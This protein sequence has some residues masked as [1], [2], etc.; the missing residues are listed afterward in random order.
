MP[1]TSYRLVY[2]LP[3]MYH[4]WLMLA[5]I[6][7][8]I[9]SMAVSD[10]LSSTFPIWDKVRIVLNIVLVFGL[11]WLIIKAMR[12]ECYL[13]LDDESFTVTPTG[14]F[15][16]MFGKIKRGLWRDFSYQ[17]GG[18]PNPDRPSYEL[19]IHLTQGKSFYFLTGTSPTEKEETERL[20]R[21]IESRVAVYRGKSVMAVG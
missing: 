12:T 10:G 5:D 19:A 18:I 21:D 11:I 9:A 2:R 8:I 20:H 16:I 15:N 6:A 1:A 3:G 7:L 14:R 13:K 17:A 4:V